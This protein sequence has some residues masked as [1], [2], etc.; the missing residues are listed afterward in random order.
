MVATMAME[1][2]IVPAD[3]RAG[4]NYG[5]DK[6][7]FMAPV[8]TGARVRC[9]VELISAED[10]GGGN[11]LIK[12]RNTLE[13]EGGLLTGRVLGDIVDGEA[14]KQHLLKLCARLGCDPRQSIAVGDGANDL[15]MMGVSGL[16][17]AY[18]AKP[19]VRE[20]AM[21]AINEG[22]LDRVLEVLA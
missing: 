22:G 7:R 3:A 5:M 6:L 15:L 4:L 1:V 12:T 18:H 19:K 10:K 11:T 14:K 2:G 9:R 13:I 17:M 20:Q 16:S 21:V 8:K